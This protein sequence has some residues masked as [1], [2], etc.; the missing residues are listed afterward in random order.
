MK[1]EDYFNLGI[2]FL[3]D[4]YV[5]NFPFFDETIE[6]EKK[7][8]IKLDP[9]NNYLLEGYI[10][11][12]VHHK[13]TNIFE[14]HDYKTGNFLKSQEDLDKDRQLAL[15]SIGVRESYPDVKDVH[16]IWHFLAF[17]KKMTSKRSLEQL[18]KL[19]ENIFNLILKIETAKEFF[20]NP[21]ILCKWC[22]FRSYCPVIKNSQESLYSSKQTLNDY[23]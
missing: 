7:I 4:Y 18:E 9:D 23:E 13:K 20:P 10:D 6:T 1:A 22:E 21:G 8:V 12:L 14:I 16:L 17:N 2:K 5:S 11:R 3:I 19:R 15:Y